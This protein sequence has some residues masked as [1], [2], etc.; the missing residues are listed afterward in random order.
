MRHH[1][2]LDNAP[3]AHYAISKNS[4]SRTVLIQ[5]G[6]EQGEQLRLSLTLEQAEH[7]ECLLQ[8]SIAGLRNLEKP[9]GK[10]LTR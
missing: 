2:L 3:S 8:Q 10:V 1:Y 9:K 7:F 4:D 5:L 6:D